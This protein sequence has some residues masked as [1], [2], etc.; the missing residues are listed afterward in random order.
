MTFFP[1]AM[2]ELTGYAPLPW[3]QRIY[4][5]LL[6]DDIPAILDVATGLAKTSVLPIWLIAL[7]RQALESRVRL[8]RRLVYVVNRRTVVDQTTDI[9]ERLRSLLHEARTGVAAEIRHALLGLCLDPEDEASP[10]AISTLRGEFADNEEWQVDPGRAAI[11][12]GTVDMI[13]SRL[14]FAGYGVSAKVRPYHAGLL[15]Q[16]VLLIHDEAHLTPAFGVLITDIACRQ[17]RAREPR[18]MRVLQLSATQRADSRDVLTLDA[19]DLDHELVRQRLNAAKRLTLEPGDLNTIV[20]RA[21]AY[22]DQRRRV[23]IYVWAPGYARDVANRVVAELGDD[24]VGLLTGTIR[25]YERDELVNKPLFAN[26]RAREGRETLDASEYLIA[27]AAGEVGVD[28]VTGPG[29][30][31]KRPADSLAGP[32]PGRSTTT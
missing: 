24:R 19:A 5:R 32:P 12:V 30:G 18:P 6:A 17:A 27:T 2:K 3:H 14:L 7:A 10:L 13:G 20:Q 4:D 26:F 1:R 15:G 11:I 16:D 29:S 23:L 21:L 9:A 31:R 22:R 28:L 8:P 25:G